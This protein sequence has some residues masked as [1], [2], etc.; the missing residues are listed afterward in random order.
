MI[1][2]VSGWRKWDDIRFATNQL[3]SYRV[4]YG[5]ALLVRVGDADGL[6]KIIRDHCEAKGYEH[7]VYRADWEKFG[8]P[9]AGPIR[10]RGML[11]GNSPEDPRQGVLADR[12]LAF[13]QPSMKMRSPGSGTVGCLIEAHLLGISVDI[14]GYKLPG[15]K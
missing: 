12:L 11:H 15:S 4:M 1:L 9:A 5:R 10:N 6:D 13:P 2:A 14:P 3:L 8:R 7:V